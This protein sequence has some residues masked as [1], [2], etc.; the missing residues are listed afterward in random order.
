MRFNFLKIIIQTLR[1][2]DAIIALLVQQ[3]DPR[4][5][6][7]QLKLCPANVEDV[8]MIAPDSID[9]EI[10]EKAKTS[11]PLCVLVVKEAEDY[12]K[13]EKSKESVK[14]ALDRVCSRLPPKPQ[15]QCT[16]FVETYYDELLEKLLSDF[17]PKDICTELSLCPALIGDL[18]EGNIRVGIEKA[19]EIP[20]VGGGNIDTNEIPD[21]T[22]NGQPI[23]A[24]ETIG[25]G[26]CMLCVE[27]IGGAEAKISKGMKKEQ[28]EQILLRECSRF[29][30]YEGVCDGFV[31]KNTDKII[32][33]LAQELSP[34]QVCQ[35]LSLCSK[36]P[37]D[38]EIDEAIIVNVVAVPSFPTTV[39]LQ[40]KE[41]AQVAA[42]VYDDPQCV[43]CEFV[44]TKLEDELKDKTT[45]DE[46]R[47][48][49]ESVCTT[50]PK[51]IS[52]QCT[53]FVEQYADLIITLIDTVPPKQIC[54]QMGLCP[55]TKKEAHLLGASE[56]TW[57]PTHFCSDHKIA[58]A[59][60]VRLLN[61]TLNTVFTSLFFLLG[62]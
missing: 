59:C 57:G 13:N 48:A 4:D 35:K 58:E 2:G 31:T 1:Y 44:M 62:N 27:V 23:N 19:D 15:L 52:K 61:Y 45:R 56:C 51:S 22:V 60:K 50:M 29:R 9:V 20:Y 37:Q 14:K 12:I 24:M 6:C 30:A 16:D 46:I 38:L 40:K 8:E 42:P 43:V 39:P 17:A 47:A 28:V 10:N 26:E 33:L 34:K 5:L 53:K 11:C 55:A 54:A 7:P 25:S 36:N 41:K 18:D 49:V 21:F 3:V 32:E